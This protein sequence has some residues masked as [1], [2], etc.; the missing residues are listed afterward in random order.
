MLT[1][2]YTHSIRFI[3]RTKLKVS[4]E[5]KLWPNYFE[6]LPQKLLNENLPKGKLGVP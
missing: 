1:D 6:S 3:E 5:F 2:G 4:T